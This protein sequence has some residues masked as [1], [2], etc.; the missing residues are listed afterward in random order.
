MDSDLSSGT[1]LYLAPELL[2]GQRPSVRSDI[3]ALGV[4]LYQAVIGDFRRPLAPGWERDVGDA[5]LC[6]DIAACADVDPM[7][8][9]ADA[10]VL[11]ASLR[12]LDARRTERT[13]RLVEEAET[14]Q[15]RGRVDRMH[16]RRPWLIATA[17]VLVA[18]IVSVSVLWIRA[19]RATQRATQEAQHATQEAAISAAVN[20]FVTEDLF[21]AADPMRFG[22]RNVTVTELLGRASQAAGERF[23]SQP[24]VEAAVRTTIGQTYSGINDYEAGEQ[25]LHQ[26]IALLDGIP[27]QKAAQDEIR[28]TLLS[29]LV[30][31]KRV[32]AIPEQLA[33]FEKNP[34]DSPTARLRIQTAKA[35]LDYRQGNLEAAVAQLET[36]RPA[37]VALM[38]SDPSLA[39]NYMAQ[40]IEV[41]WSAGRMDEALALAQ[42]R[43]AQSIRI[44]GPNDVRSVIAALQIGQTL[45]FTGRFEE[46][47]KTLAE[48]WS[49]AQTALGEESEVS[50]VIAVSLGN[51]YVE[52]KRYA[53]AASIYKRLVE[54]RLRH[55]G[56]DHQETLVAQ[57]N[58]AVLYLR[59]DR[60]NLALPLLREIYGTRRRFSGESHPDT[61]IVANLLTTGLIRSQHWQEALTWAQRTFELAQKV[62]PEDHWRRA[63]IQCRLAE[64][65]V[66][67]GQRKV[68]LANLDTAI[69][70]LTKQ[71]GVDNADTQMAI[72]L[73]AELVG[74]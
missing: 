35:W 53:D 8:R 59:T 6:E 15:L 43:Q 31:M 16:A 30:D 47:G 54:I 27:N 71:R 17:A 48:A 45:T 46:A 68:A 19:E 66:H 33:V 39:L 65:Q 60:V 20:K 62:F 41:Y 49:L 4:L 44:F 3:Y 26:A 13:Q 74:M 57:T 1:P 36:Q 29:Q 18:G 58:L 70:V 56:P 7:R 21:A 61:L 69:E 24:T 73:R 55:N 64:V 32:D 38:E 50:L 40:L 11:A 34:P 72:K 5:L 14:Q 63:V 9:L 22:Q 52:S 2:T 25:Q 37:Y 67:F 28:L 51:A 10:R 42:D 23:A 12:R